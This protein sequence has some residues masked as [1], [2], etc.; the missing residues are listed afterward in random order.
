[1]SPSVL[2][3]G[4]AG[5]GFR[6]TRPCLQIL[7]F[8]I[9]RHRFLR[10]EFIHGARIPWTVLFFSQQF[11]FRICPSCLYISTMTSCETTE[12]D[13]LMDPGTAKIFLV[14]GGAPDH[15]WEGAPAVH[16]MLS[17][18]FLRVFSSFAQYPL[19]LKAINQFLEGPGE[20]GPGGTL[21][22]CWEGGTFPP[23]SRYNTAH[24]RVLSAQPYADSSVWISSRNTLHF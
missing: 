18:Y 12:C 11:Q 13:D 17:H 1:M 20:R 23:G 16:G 4:K 22:I 21:G 6:C 2:K 19:T 9:K 3:R 5:N 24:R 10:N 7:N 15:I 14:R 8:I